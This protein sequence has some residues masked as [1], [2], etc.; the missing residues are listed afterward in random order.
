MAKEI[1]KES[2]GEEDRKRS[3][4]MHKDVADSRGRSRLHSRG[5]EARG[6]R[7]EE[8]LIA[9]YDNNLKKKASEIKI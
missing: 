6:H 9:G 4:N 5:E 1:K 3:L 8:F 2:V 7:M